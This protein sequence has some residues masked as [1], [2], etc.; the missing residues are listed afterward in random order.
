MA[1][2][3]SL[4]TRSECSPPLLNVH[5]RTNIMACR[6]RSQMELLYFGPYRLIRAV[7]PYMRNRRFGVIVNISSG[8]GLEGRP[9]MGIYAAAKAALDGMFRSAS[10]STT[11]C[12]S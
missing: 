2:S 5:D 4:A 7:L 11:A 6:A 3:N 12:S 1:S 8:A 10:A 9:S